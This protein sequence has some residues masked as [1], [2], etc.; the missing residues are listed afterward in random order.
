MNIR[1]EASTILGVRVEPNQWDATIKR[2]DVAGMIT[3]RKILE[4]VKML[5][6]RFEKIEER[7]ELLMTINEPKNTSVQSAE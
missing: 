4:L 2:L 3:N 7:L 6:K 5:C 1:E